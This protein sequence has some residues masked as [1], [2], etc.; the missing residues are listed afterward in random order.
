MMTWTMMTWTEMMMNPEPTPTDP[1]KARGTDY[2]DG[3]VADLQV[4]YPN[5]DKIKRFH[6]EWE[7]VTGYMNEWGNDCE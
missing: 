2:A 7:G 1:D 5:P 4:Y 6:D 3:G